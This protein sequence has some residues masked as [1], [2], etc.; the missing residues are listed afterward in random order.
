[1]TL[2]TPASHHD[3]FRASRIVIAM[4]AMALLGLLAALPARLEAQCTLSGSPVSFEPNPPG[5]SR[6]GTPYLGGGFSNNLAL[7]QNGGSGPYRLLMQESYGYSVL[8]LSNPVNPTALY[9]HDVRF[10][11]GGPNSVTHHGDGQNDIQTIAVSPD[12]QRVAFSTVGPAAPFNTVVGSPNG[13]G[14]GFTLWGDFS[15]QGANGTVIQHIGSR[16]IAYDMLPNFATAS[17]ITTLPTSSLAELNMASEATSWPGGYLAS[18]AGNYLLYQDGGAVQ[19]IDASNPGPA[20][21]ITA[22]YPRTT[23]TSAD[24]GGRTIAFYSAAVDPADATKL[25]VLVELNAQA[26]EN[27][28]SYGLL[29]VSGSLAKVSA[30]PI[31]RVPSQ[32]SDVW[33]SNP[34]PSSALIASN[35]SLFV[36]MWAQRALPSLL[37][38]LYSTTVAA[39][40]AVN[41]SAR[42]GV[43]DIP[44][45]FYSNFSPG[46]PM[47]GFSAGNSIYAYLPTGSSA[48]VIP[49]SCVS[50]N[51]PAVA[52]MTVANQAG[53][54]LNNGDTVFL[55][56]QIT[57]T[58]SVNPSTASQPLTGFG[59]NFDFDF[60]AGAASDDNWAGPCTSPRLKAPDNG[61]FGSPATPPA[62]ITVV[63]PC[64][65]QVAG[66]NPGSGTGCWTSVTTNGAFGGPDFTGAEARVPRRPSRSRSRRTTLSAA[67]A[68]ACSR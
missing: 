21:S 46:Q 5:V 62:L 8:D 65:F 43:L 24:F 47:R 35:G 16:Y 54:P 36:L 50:Q 33:W 37:F 4:A 20:G 13:A 11:V 49:M 17:D 42:P 57:I 19:V 39:W 56:D 48:Y 25:W 23:I 59:W 58:P 52:S 18:I 30:G 60:H 12:G 63:G 41:S 68:R 38:E 14:S 10:P 29:T 44:T 6:G 15:G 2:V 31:W 32:A 51:A 7:Y 55:G 53:A 9:Y 1:M 3:H 26:G 27:S 28:P 66:T 22:S 40:G 64:D 45:A 34:G 67:R 61:A